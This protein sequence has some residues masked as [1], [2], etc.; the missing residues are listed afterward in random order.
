MWHDDSFTVAAQKQ[1][2]QLIQG[3]QLTIQGLNTIPGLSS[4]TT[5]AIRSASN[6]LI[7]KPTISIYEVLKLARDVSAALSKDSAA[8]FSNSLPK[9]NFDTTLAALEAAYSG[10]T[11]THGPG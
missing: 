10:P 8:A 11:T 1:E 5:Q 3:L 7:Q 9:Y 2:A 4:A 6:K